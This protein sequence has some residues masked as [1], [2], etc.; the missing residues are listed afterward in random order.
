MTTWTPGTPPDGASRAAQSIQTVQS[1]LQTTVDGINNAI[2]G[3]TG[4]TEASAVQSNMSTVKDNVSSAVDAAS[5]ANANT[6]S[7]VD[8]IHQAVYGGNATGTPAS[9]VAANL[10]QIPQEN[11]VINAASGTPNPVTFDSVGAGA[12]QGGFQL[13]ENGTSVSWTHT[14]GA[15]GNYLLIPCY[16]DGTVAGFSPSFS[17]VA[18]PTGGTGSQV[19]FGQISF[20]DESNI[21]SLLGGMISPGTY[22]IA[23]TCDINP[24][25]GAGIG[26]TANGFCAA[27][28]SYSYVNTVAQ[29]GYESY[30]SSSTSVS[31]TTNESLDNSRA[32]TVCMFSNSIPSGSAA[33]SGLTGLTQRLSEAFTS[34]NKLAIALG[35]VTT[36]PSAVSYR[37]TA[38]S[39]SGN[40]WMT[41][42]VTLLPAS[43]DT[44]GS[45]AKMTCTSTTD[46]AMATPTTAAPTPLFPSGTFN[47]INAQTSDIEVV[48]HNSFKVTYAGTYIVK[49]N[50]MLGSTSVAKITGSYGAQF[51]PFIVVNGVAVDVGPTTI[52]YEPGGP[53]ST[54]GMQY[55]WTGFV[56]L[57][58]GDVVAMTAWC[59]SD[60]AA[61]AW[62][63]I[64]SSALTYTSM[65]IT[66]ANRSL[67]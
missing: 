38:A 18:T 3:G 36:S 51:V 29:A 50:V 1:G 15:T 63:F 23:L 52:M 60:I 12:V 53:T 62:D 43:S 48:N 27:S 19:T 24:D 8:G 65:S 37:A 5:A 21:L 59:N 42:A 34:T 67:Y 58:P 54:G 28:V 64:G 40:S 11:V 14:V 56:Y 46:V 47:I 26:A 6:Q 7:V 31:L 16:F 9:A 30:G 35:D 45:Y 66:L 20:N 17:A 4:T 22:T 33:L 41:L 61:V 13:S 55:G 57:S 25:A 39:G 10:Q 44:V 2:T 49:F 32:L